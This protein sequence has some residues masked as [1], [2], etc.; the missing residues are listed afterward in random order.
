MLPEYS[1]TNSESLAQ[2]STPMTENNFFSRELF[3]YWHTLYMH[4]VALEFRIV[5][6]AIYIDYKKNLK[7]C[8]N[9][10]KLCIF[11]GPFILVDTVKK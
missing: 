2:I 8:G 6:F 7:S 10:W 4:F 11:V 9:Y 3:S 1:H 5:C